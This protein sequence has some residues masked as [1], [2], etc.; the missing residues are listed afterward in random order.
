MTLLAARWLWLLPLVAALVGAYVWVQVRGRRQAAVRFTNLA[1]LQRLAPKRPGW[2][3]HV[4]AGL[5]ALSLVAMV[6]S[7]ARPTHEVRVA[8]RRAVV[9]MAVDVSLSMQATDVQP[10]RLKAAKEAAERF[11]RSLPG[12]VR[13]GLVSFAGS[14]DLLVPPTTDH[15]AVV[16]AV[17]ALRLREGTAIGDAVLASLQA[18]R[19]DAAT[20]TAK[21]APATVVLMSDGMTTVGTPDADAGAQA[22]ERKVPV[23]TIAFGTQDGAVTIHGERIPVPVDV[24]K[25]ADLADQTGGRS[26][27][28]D[29]AGKLERAYRDISTSVGY[30]HR[31]R[32]VTTVLVGAAFVLALLAAAASLRWTARLP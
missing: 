13:L 4:G 14:T 1:L 16:R 24:A 9:V 28:A 7:L 21:R 6:L 32:E 18:I 30:V 19:T 2:R 10:N 12:T 20:E 29:S 22:K 17:K 25:L 3:R 11:A 8:R 31:R 23:T 27:T 26:F 5:L 15:D